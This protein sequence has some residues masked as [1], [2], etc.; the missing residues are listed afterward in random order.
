MSEI[1]LFWPDRLPRKPQIGTSV[2][3]DWPEIVAWLRD[4]A[5][6]GAEWAACVRLNPTKEM[7]NAAKASAGGWIWASLAG[8][9]RRKVS[10]GWLFGFGLDFDEGIPLET[11]TALLGRY[12]LCVHSTFKHTATAPRYRALLPLREPLTCD[13]YERAWKTIEHHLLAA[14]VRPD[15]VTKDGSRLWYLPL[16]RSD[17][18]YV[19]YTHRGELLD[20]KAAAAWEPPRTPPKVAEP[21]RLS[22]RYLRGALRR[23]SEAVATAGEGARNDTLNRQAHSLLRLPI[24]PTVAR[25]ALIDASVSAGLSAGEA[26][27]TFDSAARA[28][29]VS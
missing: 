13:E 9:V 22:D 16:R 10:I 2:I 14:G 1:T 12:E 21:T 27:K 11:I 28:R 7:L 18:D 17:A 3:A 23:A 4:P 6:L 24:D 26:A 25:S 29:Q 20:G 5:W 8:G 19:F 15:P